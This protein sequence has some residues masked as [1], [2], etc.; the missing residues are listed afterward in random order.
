[1]MHFH[2]SFECVVLPLWKTFHEEPARSWKIAIEGKQTITIWL[3]F[4]HF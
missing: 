1:M 2:A 4:P 3:L